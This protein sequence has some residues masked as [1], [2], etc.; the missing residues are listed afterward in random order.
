MVRISVDERNWS[1]K[2]VRWTSILIVVV[3]L[4]VACENTPVPTELPTPPLYNTPAP[5]VES[6]IRSYLDA[7][8]V[9]DYASMYTMLAQKSRADLTEENFAK[10]FQ[11]ALVAMS[12]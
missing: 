11:D 5:S 1:M 4:L 6:A 9:E 7:L 12:A 8:K 2:S 10:K 3:F